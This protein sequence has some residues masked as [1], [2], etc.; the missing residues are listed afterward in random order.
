MSSEAAI[1]IQGLSKVYN[2]FAKPEDRLKQMFWRHRRQYFHEFWALRDLTLEIGHGETVGIVGRN[3]SG[4]STLLQIVAG[5]L[6]PTFGEVE[7]HGRVAALLELGSGFN[8]EFTGRENIQL[9]AA[10]L[11]L[12]D[13]EIA[14]RYD[15]IVAFA[16]I[17]EFVEQPVKT[18]SSGMHARLAFAVAINV[19][20]QILAVDEI[21]AVGDEAFSRKCFARIHELKKRGATILFVTHSAG[22]V[23]ELC[24]RAVLLDHG[25]RLFTGPPKAVIGKYQRLMYAPADRQAA[26]RAEIRE[27]DQ[28]WALRGPDDAEAPPPRAA[29]SEPGAPPAPANGWAEPATVEAQAAGG[30]TGG[31]AADTEEAFFDPHLEPQSTVD[32]VPRGAKI[33]GVGIYDAAGRRVN[34]LILGRTYTYRYQVEFLQAATNVVFGM[35]IKTIQGVEVAGLISHPVAQ[36]HEFVEPGVTVEASFEFQNLLHPGAYFTNAGVLGSLEGEYQYLHRILDVAMF[37][38]QPVRDLTSTGLVNLSTGA[39]VRLTTGSGEP[40]E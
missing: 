2:I 30:G 7:V 36:G 14:D 10:I 1:R 38:V 16:D 19:D 13:Q 39:P 34:H 6:A 24:D 11:G 35:L 26:I 32:Y 17:G 33:T 15:D 31:G 27:L 22:A 28:W 5:T 18:Y 40:L 29:D 25:E 37:R 23:V 9:N 20:P 4:K 3:G 21:L 8:P 12:T